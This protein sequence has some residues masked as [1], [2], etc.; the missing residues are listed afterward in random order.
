MSKNP[1]IPAMVLSGKLVLLLIKTISPIGP[2]GDDIQG[3][4]YS[5][6]RPLL[7]SQ[8]GQY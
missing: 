3:D 8:R 6:M 1:V 4:D 7:T 2:L 5:I